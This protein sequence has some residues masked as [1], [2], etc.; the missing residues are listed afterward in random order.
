MLGGE[1]AKYGHYSSHSLGHYLHQAWALGQIWQ[2][3]LKIVIK[4]GKKPARRL[5]FHCLSFCVCRQDDQRYS[6]AC[7]VKKYLF[8]KSLRVYLSSH[9]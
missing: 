7:N 2:M 1:E 5:K 6:N 3:W 9:S 4:L 8:I